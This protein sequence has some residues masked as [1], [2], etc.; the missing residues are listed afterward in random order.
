MAAP[1][2][3]PPKVKQVNWDTTPEGMAHYKARRAQSKAPTPQ[4]TKRLTK[5]RRA[6]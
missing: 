3:T 5:G 1:K 4:P 2:N 6:K